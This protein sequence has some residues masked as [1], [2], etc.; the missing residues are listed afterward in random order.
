MEFSGSE[1][2]WLLVGDFNFVLT[3]H[4]IT[5]NITSKIVAA[6]TKGKTTTNV[7]TNRS[8]DEGDEHDFFLKLGFCG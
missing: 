2:P 5:G 6:N 8:R 7:N 1:H 3:A 4:E